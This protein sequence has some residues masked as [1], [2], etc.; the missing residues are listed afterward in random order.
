MCIV[1][2]PTPLLVT[3][4]F[5][6]HKYNETTNSSLHFYCCM[7]WW[8]TPWLNLIPLKFRIIT[9]S[10]VYNNVS[11]GLCQRIWGIVI[12]KNTPRD[13]KNIYQEEFQN[14]WSFLKGLDVW[15]NDSASKVLFTQALGLGLKS[16]VPM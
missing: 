9:Q 13:T 4:I 10:Q 11:S 15:K 14:S 2:V 8:L 1:D 7:L 16:P 5:L 12:S 6:I 3:I